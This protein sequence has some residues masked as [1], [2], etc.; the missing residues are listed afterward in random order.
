MIDRLN[1]F[2][3]FYIMIDSKSML[4]LY[5]HS[6]DIFPRLLLILAYSTYDCRIIKP[7]FL[8]LNI[9]QNLMANFSMRKA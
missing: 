9:L 4:L 8:Q 7:F 2:L 5:K 1:H 3:L 6:R